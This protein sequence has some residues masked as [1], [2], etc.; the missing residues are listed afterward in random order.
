MKTEMKREITELRHKEATTNKI[1]ASLAADRE[2]SAVLRGLRNHED[3][4]SI[5]NKIRESPTLEDRSTS[6]WNLLD[7]SMSNCS[8]DERYAST[9]ASSVHKGSESLLSSPLGSP[10]VMSPTPP[11]TEATLRPSQPE[12]IKILRERACQGPTD[13]SDHRLIKHLFSIY[14]VWIHPSDMILDMQSFVDGYEMG[15]DYYCSTFLVYAVC[16]AACDHLT[17]G[18]EN[19]EGKTTD[20]PMLRQNLI[21]IARTLEATADQNTDTTRQAST[22][23]SLVHAR[24]RN[25]LQ[26]P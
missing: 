14:W 24:P 13:L 7:G 5:A 6:S 10:A 4:S 21:A 19:V 23:L 17:T 3:L 25:M 22:I 12:S 9:D 11:N 20:V 18:W 15:L 1:F 26:N 16:I 8:T 2:T